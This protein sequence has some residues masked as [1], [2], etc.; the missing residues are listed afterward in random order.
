MIMSFKRFQNKDNKDSGTPICL[1][2]ALVISVILIMF[3][4]AL[5]M[6]LE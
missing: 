1:I 6:C 3:L 2:V 5:F 4:L